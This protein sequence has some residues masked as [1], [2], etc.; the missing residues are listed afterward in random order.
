MMVSLLTHIC[1]TGSDPIYT[2]GYRRGIFL[3]GRKFQWIV[4]LI[5]I[6]TYSSECFTLFFGIYILTRNAPPLE[7]D[8]YGSDA[9]QYEEWYIS[10]A[11]YHHYPV[12]I[13]PVL[14]GPPWNVACD[15]WNSGVALKW[16]REKSIDM[17]QLC[18]IMRKTVS[19]KSG[20]G[21]WLDK[22]PQRQLRSWLMLWAMF[23]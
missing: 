11:F 21:F 7:R 20:V 8:K 17:S 23:A 12:S 22:S 5:Y 4:R 9:R 1:W 6:F 18:K 13:N 10:S 16:Q 2:A 3:F 14:L 19:F 15:Y